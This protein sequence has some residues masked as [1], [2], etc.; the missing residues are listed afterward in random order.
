MTIHSSILGW[1]I[2]WT[3]EPGKLR[4]MGSQRVGHDWV[5]DLI[6]MAQ[7]V[8]NLHA[9]QKTWVWFLGW[10]DPLEKGMTTNS[11]ILAW[12]IPWT[13]EPGGL[14]CIGLQRVGHDWASNTF[15]FTDI[16]NKC[17]F[18]GKDLLWDY[19]IL[20]Y[21]QFASSRFPSSHSP[22]DL[23]TAWHTAYT[24]HSLSELVTRTS[25]QGGPLSSLLK[26]QNKFHVRQSFKCLKSR[27]HKITTEVLRCL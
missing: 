17:C 20:A 2:P 7:M 1:W 16:L 12:R 5:T 9:V 10:E 13:E 25:L 26:L 8:K 3:E 15:T 21:S 18:E 24:Q 27:N 19:M 4:S 11:S 23:H 6:W 22:S 14:Q